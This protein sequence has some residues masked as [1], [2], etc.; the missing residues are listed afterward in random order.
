MLTN[1]HE[2]YSAHYF[3]ELLAGDLKEMLER[4]KALADEHPDSES[5]REPPARLRSLAQ[6]YFRALEKIRRSPDSLAETQRDFLT[7]LLP[8]LGYTLAPSWRAVGQGSNAVRIPL[9]GEVTTQSGA[10]ALWIIE[11]L[12]IG[13]SDDELSTDPLSLTPHPSQYAADPQNTNPQL[14]GRQ[15][16]SSSNPRSTISDP[17]SL[18]TWED[19]LGKDIFAQEEPPRWVIFLSFGQIVLCDRMKWA[20]RRFLSCDLRVATMHR[21]KGLEFDH[22]CLADCDPERLASL[23]SARQSTERCLMHVAATRT[24]NSLLVVSLRRTK[25]ASSARTVTSQPMLRRPINPS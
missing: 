13:P 4:W 5:H 10:P 19:I 14:P 2:Y 7:S 15:L 25:G 9:I 6:P 17:L 23:P 22:V 16:S 20:E 3:A 21:I 12:P 1:H 11:T 8:V 18:P 24:K